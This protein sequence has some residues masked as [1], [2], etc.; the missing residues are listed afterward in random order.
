[1]SVDS[2]RS[3]RYEPNH[4]IRALPATEQGD[5]SMVPPPLDF[6][7]DAEAG[8]KGEA[9]SDGD[10]ETRTKIFFWEVESE[11]SWRLDVFPGQ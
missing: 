11:S 3:G 1:M 6:Q 2:K 9:I 7:R 5:A 8:R 10:G 4:V